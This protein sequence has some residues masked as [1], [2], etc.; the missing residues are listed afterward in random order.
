MILGAAVL[1]TS[2][3]R[4]EANLFDLSA[5]ERMAALQEAVIANL[6]GESAGWELRYFPTEESAGYAFLMK[7][8]KNGSVEVAA[9]NKVSTN[10][11]YKTE[12]GLWGTDATQ[13]CI[14]SLR[15]Y[16]NI[17]SVF[18]D[19]GTDGVG[20]SGDYEFIVLKNEK[21]HIRL[22]G[23]KHGAY[24][25]M[26]PLPAGQDWQ[27]YFKLVDK[28]NELVFSGNDG[29]DM[30]YSAP[31]TTLQ[32]TYEEG[33]FTFEQDGTENQLGFVI[34]PSGLHFYSGCPTKTSAKVRDFVINSDMTKLEAT[35]GNAFIV[36]NYGAADFFTL[37]FEN[38]ARWI[39]SDLDTDAATQAAIAAV[40]AAAEAKGATISRLGYERYATT[41]MKGKVIYNYNVY[42]GYTVENVLIEGYIQMNYSQKDGKILFSYKGYDASLAALLQRIDSDPVKAAKMIVEPLCG[43]FE[44]SS[45]TGSTLNMTQLYLTEGSKKIHVIADNEL[46]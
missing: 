41:D 35:N 7:F 27:E 9:K 14:I 26:Y 24:M 18:A 28:F 3:S 11:A 25:D 43:T 32:L 45:Y 4:E 13:G 6:T 19:P 22:K 29:I 40:K 10:N 46:Y 1:L 38:K 44:P 5:A 8:D 37:K 21:G 31:D 17:L 30:T 39:Y 20:H 15:S 34:T 36:S 16:I 42:V 33:V 23:K 12:V 2:C